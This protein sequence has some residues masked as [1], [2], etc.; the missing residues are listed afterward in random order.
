MLKLKHNF[1]GGQNI[2][3]YVT[4][5]DGEF[6]AKTEVNVNVLNGTKRYQG[7]VPHPPG[8]FNFPSYNKMPPPS[9]ANNPP[10][11]IANNPPPI[12]GRQHQQKTY[13]EAT[14]EPPQVS[15]VN[16]ISKILKS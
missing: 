6:K 10:P 3:L 13:P 15:N 2:H 5:S 4:V 16:S 8:I 11:S 14:S 12:P 9:M 7:N 1:Q